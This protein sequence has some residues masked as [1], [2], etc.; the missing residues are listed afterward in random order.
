MELVCN[1]V[2]IILQAWNVASSRFMEYVVV[3]C[4][5]VIQQ[6]YKYVILAPLQLLR[7]SNAYNY[8]YSGECA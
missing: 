8:I 1:N 4:W 2:T 7:S 6:R 3:K 5:L